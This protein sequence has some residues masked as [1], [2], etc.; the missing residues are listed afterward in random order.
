MTFA[1]FGMNFLEKMCII[2]SREDDTVCVL[3]ILQS[4]TVI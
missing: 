1:Q 2:S 4:K 3:E